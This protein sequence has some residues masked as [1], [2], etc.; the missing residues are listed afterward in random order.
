MTLLLMMLYG[1]LAVAALALTSLT[2]F[3]IVVIHRN[4]VA[5]HEAVSIPVPIESPE[6]P[7][8]V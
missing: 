7:A 6:T 4:F 3:G 1:T 8:G 2:M 5:R